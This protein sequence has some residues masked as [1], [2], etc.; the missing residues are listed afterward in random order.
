MSRLVCLRWCCCVL[1]L[2]QASLARADLPQLLTA[3][4]RAGIPLQ[5][6][7]IMAQGVQEDA[8]PLLAF[9][10][11][12]PQV[13]ASTTKLL[14]SLVALDVLGP[15]FAWQTRA[16]ALGTI[17]AGVLH[18]DLLIVGGGDARL[19]SK[20]LIAWFQTLQKKKGLKEIRGN[21]VVH[22]GLFQTQA[23]DHAGTPTPSAGNPH[24]A[25]PEAFM[26]D[27]GV[28]RVAIAGSTQGLQVSYQPALDGVVLEQQVLLSK[29][30]CGAIQH[31]V[32][33]V[34]DD[35]SEPPKLR[36]EG[37]WAPGC[38][39]KQLT[40]ATPPGSR[41]SALAVAAAWRAAGGVL[42]GGA[43]QRVDATGPVIPKGLKPLG[44]FSSPTLGQ[45]L[46]SMNKVSD[47]LMARHLMLSW[48]KGFPARPATLKEARKRFV[49]WR[50]KL[51]LSA[52]DVSVDN[53]S[54]LSR[55]ERA[56]PSTMTNLLRTAW[57]GTWGKTLFDSLPVAG[58]D[59]TLANRMTRSVARGNA[60]LKTGTLSD[61][62]A[63]A[64]YVRGNSGQIYAVTLLV[65][66]PRA[67]KALQ[68]MDG[69]IEWIITNG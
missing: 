23:Q 34:F 33:V 50:Q 42:A 38:L 47:N 63:L 3:F 10:E 28:I 17:Q 66:D 7:S 37:E 25:W 22:Q 54:G 5:H 15:K 2:F 19:S 60:F 55:G 51:G 30:R 21:I 26:V 6:V 11:Q 59:G 45:L 41:F 69:L 29:R 4:E 14:T 62:R 36:I 9:N 64:G 27:E 1:A 65:N 35:Q 20:E 43:F 44:T 49:Q 32:E 13:L 16:Y 31:P 48:S 56:R 40:L 18:G 68:A 61:V 8:P 53:G 57:R 46:R 24:H 58:Q 67:D 12:T 39:P 52:E